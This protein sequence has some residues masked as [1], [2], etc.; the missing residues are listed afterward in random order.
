MNIYISI[1]MLILFCLII[2]HIF[3]SVD[4]NLE[5]FC[6]ESGS[7]KNACAAIANSKNTAGISHTQELID[8]TKKHIETL[9]GKVSKLEDT[10]EAEIGKNIKGI[11][12][13]ID[14]NAKVKDAIS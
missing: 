3:V 9:L 8:E 11:Q 5:G 7:S 14:N 13:N 10:A 1:I 6:S 2:R 4:N 12:K